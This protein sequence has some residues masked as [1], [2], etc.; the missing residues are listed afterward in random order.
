M[1][2]EFWN[3]T[4]LGKGGCAKSGEFSEKCLG[5]GRSL[6]IQKLML[7]IMGT[8]KRAFAAWNWYKRVISGFR[9]CFFNNCIEKNQNK[10]NFEKGSSSHTIFWLFRSNKG[11]IRATKVW[12]HEYQWSFSIPAWEIFLSLTMCFRGTSSFVFLFFFF[13]FFSLCLCH[14]TFN[15]YPPFLIILNNSKQ[16]KSL[17]PLQLDWK[18]SNTIPPPSPPPPSLL[19]CNCIR[20]YNFVNFAGPWVSGLWLSNSLEECD[21][22]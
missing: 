16:L 10:K 14:K 18:H 7:Q 17:K 9:T 2:F 19:C 8:L 22:L 3:N 4:Y 1:P 6:S 5:G 15:Q 12:Q 13:L 21:F 20:I 11:W